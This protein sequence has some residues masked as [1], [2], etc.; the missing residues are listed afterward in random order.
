MVNSRGMPAIALTSEEHVFFDA[1]LREKLPYGVERYS[2]AE[3]RAACNK[4]YRRHPELRKI[5]LSYLRTLK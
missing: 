4:V 5:A 1:L 2:P 3:I